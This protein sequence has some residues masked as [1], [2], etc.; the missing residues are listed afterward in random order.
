MKKIL[1]VLV[2]V[3]S[4][5]LTFGQKNVRQT[6]SNFLKDGKLD[7][8][9]ENIN[10]C[11]QDASMAQDAKAWFIKGN[12]YLEIA[13]SKDEKF[14]SL[15]P[16][17]LQKALEAYKKA[18][19]Y[20]P[21]KDYYDDIFAKLTW[22]HNNYYNAAVD[23]YNRKSYKEAMQNFEDAASTLSIANVPDTI[24][25][26]YAAFNANLAGEKEK[27]K[28]YYIDLLK[29]GARSV[30]IYA[31]LADLYRID[32]DSASA[33]KVIRLGK[34]LYP[35]NLQ[36]TLSESNVYIFF[37]NVPK[38]LSTLTLAAEK[39]STNYL[40][41]NAIGINY[42]KIYEDTLKPPAVRS[43][44]YK[45]AEV[46][47]LKAIKLKSDFYDVQLNIASLYFNSAVPIALKANG[48]PLDAKEEYDKL[49]N[50]ANAYYKL[51]LPYLVRAD[52]LEPNDMNSLNSLR[53]IYS[54][55]GDAANL[56]II[57]GRILELRKK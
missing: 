34:K 9:L 41:F 5:T 12:I 25:L 16:Q 42:Q 47:Y 43:E 21:K 46:A 32:K 50:Q 39:D 19:E 27:Q 17:P 14:K 56:K 3:F 49:T 40:V 26:L 1:F 52:Q 45:K 23:S 10:I 7:K 29:N 2:L 51:A 30:V 15:D 33:L 57:Q 22:Q 54:S 55:L 36:M 4:I 37:N 13:N 28:Q 35:N 44:A 24:S 20:D 11:L 48:L 38:A 8:A 18:I 6:A 53:Q 31:T